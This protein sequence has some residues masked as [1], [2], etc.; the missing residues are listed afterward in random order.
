MEMAAVVAEVLVIIPRDPLAKRPGR[1]P[2]RQRPSFMAYYQ[3]SECECAGGKSAVLKA[4][5]PERQED[6]EITEEASEEVKVEAVREG[7]KRKEA[8]T[9]AESIHG[10]TSHPVESDRYAWLRGPSSL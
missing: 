7:H 5:P 8:T 6:G 2:G 3:R 10:E 9:E 4:L 1:A